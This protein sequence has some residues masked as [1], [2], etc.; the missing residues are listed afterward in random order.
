[1]KNQTKTICIL[2]AALALLAGCAVGPGY[3]IVPTDGPTTLGPTPGD[4][5]DVP[6]A[7]DVALSEAEAAKLTG[8]WDGDTYTARLLIVENRE[9]VA[10]ATHLGGGSYT[11]TAFV[12]PDGDQLAQQRLLS[13]WARRLVQLHGVE[14]APR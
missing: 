9:G 7:L 1:M 8:S 5:D 3:E 12:E 2:A 13:A 6:R 11:L 10:T 14:W 4:R